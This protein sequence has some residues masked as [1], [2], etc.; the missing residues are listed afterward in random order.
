MTE[1]VT[2][3]FIRSETCLSQN[4]PDDELKT[5][6]MRA[7]DILK[8]LLGVQFYD[9]IESQ[10]P[11]SFD[12]DNSALFDPYIKKFLA[13]Q[14]MLFWLPYANLKTTRSG[15]RVHSEENSTPATDAQVGALVADMRNMAQFH[16]EGILGFIRKQRF[17]DDSKYP[18]YDDD[19]NT[20]TLGTGFAITPVRK[21]ENIQTRI[22]KRIDFNG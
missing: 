16:K 14:S 19:C 7:Q 22:D 20:K 2:Y 3:A 8:G 13:W 9:Q 5:P 4:I 6:L 17:S 18:L 1:L 15:L 11:S 10:F 12:A 21:K